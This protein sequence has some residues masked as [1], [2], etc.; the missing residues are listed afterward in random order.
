MLQVRINPVLCLEVERAVAEAFPPTDDWTSHAAESKLAEVVATVSGLVFM[1]QER[2]HDPEYLYPAVHY[3]KHVML[4]VRALKQWPRWLRP[5]AS[6]FM[7]ELRHAQVQRARFKRYMTPI[8]HDRRERMAR[9]EAVPDDMLRWILARAE[10]QGVADD[11]MASIQL[12]LSVAAIHTTTR[13][14]THV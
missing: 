7:P 12:G 4:A 13:A 11:D 8:V 2:C 9:G 1:G 10:S 6:L 14:V 5:L 3:T